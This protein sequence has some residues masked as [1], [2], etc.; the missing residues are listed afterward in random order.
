MT[1]KHQITGLG[2]KKAD[3]SMFIFTARREPFTVTAEWLDEQKKEPA[4]GE[5]IDINDDGTLSLMTEAPAKPRFESRTYSDGTTASGTAPLPTKSPA[6]QE[7]DEKKSD[8]Q[9]DSANGSELSP[10]KQYAAKPTIVRAAEIVGVYAK[11]E[12]GNTEVAF[13]DGST[14]VATSDMTARLHPSVGDYWVI[15]P[16]PGGDYEYLNP[17][18][19]FELKY[20]PVVIGVDMAQ[21]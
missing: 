12:D 13:T 14:K 21:E 2:P 9:D 6:Q 8:G 17:K 10:F 18:A 19:V 3:G 4:V 1:T 5:F 15:V 20:A 7:A 11:T 16:Q